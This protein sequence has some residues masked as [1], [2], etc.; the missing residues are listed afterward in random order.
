M[1][2]DCILKLTLK[3]EIPHSS[4]N[5]CVNFS[6]STCLYL[7]IQFI[8]SCT[9]W[10]LARLSL[11]KHGPAFQKDKSIPPSTVSCQEL[12]ILWGKCKQPV[13]V[14]SHQN[15]EKNRLRR[16]A[17]AHFE[18]D[19]VKRSSAVVVLIWIIRNS[20]KSGLVVFLTWRPDSKHRSLGMMLLQFLTL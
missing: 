1:F 12:C 3:K 15:T 11:A 20:V 13:F 16:P 5:V 4:Q 17:A 14:S 10:A 7:N 18:E 9:V 19:S 2:V 8:T 6:I